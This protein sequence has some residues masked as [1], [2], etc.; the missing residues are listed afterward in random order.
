M[1]VIAWPEI[2][3]FHNIRSFLKVDSGAAWQA[4]ELLGGNS[5]VHYKSKVKLH[6]TNCAVQLYSDGTVI[7]QSRTTDLS[8]ASD[9]LGFAKFIKTNE[10]AW[11]S[12]SYSNRSGMVIY[13]EWVGPGIQKS[14]V[15][16][17]D[18]PKKV[19]AVFAARHMSEGSDLLVVDPETLESYVRGIPDV[20]VIPWYEQEITIDWT[21]TDEELN[22]DVA[23]INTWVSTVEAVDPWVSAVFGKQGMG[24]GLVF[25]P[26]SHPGL[27][28]FKNLAFKAKG[29][30]HQVVKQSAPAQVNAEKAASVDQFLDMVLTEPRAMQGALAVSPGGTLKFDKSLTG[31]FVSWIEKDVKKETMDEML[32]SNLLWEQVQKPLAAKARAWYLAN[33][34]K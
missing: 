9:Q 29:K 33:C 12:G 2:E 4:F 25:Y 17:S 34:G 27:E 31:K 23:L 32:A 26:V 28:N 18:L 30:E 21:R 10:E 11:K 19:F 15:A 24:E 8:K 5:K 6:G 7:P 13:G 1:A 14:N 20:Y 22:A 3:G 16:V